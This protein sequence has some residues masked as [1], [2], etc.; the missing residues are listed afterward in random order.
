MSLSDRRNF[1][2]LAGATALVGGCGFT[3]VYGPSGGA[4]LLQGQVGLDTPADRNGFLINQ[5]IED[6][7]GRASPGAY[8]LSV[9]LKTD[10]E[11][12]GSTSV[13]ETTRY[14]LIGSATFAL[15]D[16]ATQRV[17]EF[18]KSG[19]FHGIFRNRIN[20]CDTGS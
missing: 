15:R 6:R 7:L 13:G 16:R 12:L 17:V 3:P 4:Q 5:R 2:K 10:R 20:G 1:L 11:G 9:S 14:H 19:E 8:A 18:R